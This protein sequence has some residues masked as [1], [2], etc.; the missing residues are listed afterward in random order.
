MSRIFG[1]LGLALLLSWAALSGGAWAQQPPEDEAPANPEMQR[2]EIINIEG[3]IARAILLNNA[4][5]FR[6]VYAD[7]FAGTLSHGQSVNRNTLI[8]VV[9]SS[10]VKYDVSISSDV[11]VRIYQDMAV[12]TCLWTTRGTF[13]GERFNSQMRITHVFVNTPRGWHVIASQNTALPPDSYQPL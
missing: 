8:E 9:Q 13:R 12:A 5:F 10:D 2:Q 3:E 6:R 4:T 1:L 11:K 7:D